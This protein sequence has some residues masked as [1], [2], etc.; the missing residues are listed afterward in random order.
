MIIKKAK[1]ND[2]EEILNLQK[3]AYISEAELYDDYSIEPLIETI[4]EIKKEFNNGIILK[5]INDGPDIIGSVRAVKADDT[6]F[7]QK[8]IVH[9]DF[10]NKGIGKNLLD[11]IEKYFVEIDSRIEFRLF[12][13][14]KSF[15]NIHLYEKLGYK[16][17]KIERIS[18]N[19]KFVHFKK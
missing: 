1:F 13:G 3:L 5:A 9:P 7:I 6:V 14:Y 8:L 17:Y 15:K 10:Q 12:T 16:K 18:E 2:L 4:D 11:S 19:L